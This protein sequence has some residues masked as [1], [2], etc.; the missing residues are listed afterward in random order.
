MKEQVNVV[1]YQ[2][3]LLAYERIKDHIV[4]TPLDPSLF[5]NTDEKQ[6]YFKLECY[7]TVKSFKIRGALNKMMTL[8]DEQK[9][10]GVATISSGNH[11]VSVSYAAHL[12]NI[13]HALVIVPETTPE[14]KIARIEFFGAQVVTLGQDYDEAY[15]LGMQRI[16]DEG[17]T[18]IDPYFDDPNI[19]AGQGTVAVEVLAQN[20]NIDTIVVPVGGGG[21]ITGISIAAK[22]IRPSIRIIGVQTEACPAMVRALEDHVFYADFPSEKTICDA[23]V[24]GIGK[25]AYEMAAQCIDDLLVVSEEEIAKATS[26]VLKKEKIMIE[27]SSATTVAAVQKYREQIGGRQIA[28]VL[29][30]GNISEELLKQLIVQ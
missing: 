30:G 22:A 4:Q 8:S 25:R 10:K 29:S 24:G 3:I 6:Y 18:Y 9:E 13:E 15:R 28:L 2:D 19:Y 20:P 11:G 17:Q 12:L 26:F 7:Q 14:S 21:L 1:T 23:L 27:P 16:H 5:L